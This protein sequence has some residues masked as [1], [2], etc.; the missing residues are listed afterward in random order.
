MTQ[1]DDASEPFRQRGPHHVGQ[2]HSDHDRQPWRN[3]EVEGQ[4]I[5]CSPDTE[6]DR[7]EDD[8]LGEQR[9]GPVELL[10]V[11]LRWKGRSVRHPRTS[12]VDVAEAR[13]K[14]LKGRVRAG[15]EVGQ[16]DVR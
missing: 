5:D 16:A 14:G 7:Q 3:G 4:N 12:E 6:Q 13:F 11:L 2:R 9:I 8:A 1:L 10:S 15:L